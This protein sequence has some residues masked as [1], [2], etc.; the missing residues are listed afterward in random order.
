MR[1]GYA[2]ATLLTGLVVAA[3]GCAHSSSVSPS[4]DGFANTSTGLAPMPSAFQVTGLRGHPSPIRDHVLTWLII[5]SAGGTQKVTPDQVVQWV[6]YTMTKQAD[7][8]IAHALGMKTIFYTDP[9]RV[10]KSDLMYT[11]D[12][13]T[14]AHDCSGSRITVLTKDKFLMD[15]HSKHLWSLWP[16]A[17]TTMM[18]WGG[19][20][21]YDYVFED[22]ADSVNAL[23]MSA[24]PCN[25]NQVDWTTN[26]NLLDKNLGYNIIYNGLSHVP[27]DTESPAPAFYLNPTAFGGMAEDCYVGRSPSGYHYGLNWM[28][29]ENTEIGMQQTGKLFV[30]HGDAYT[31]SHTSMALR[32]YFYASVLLSYD[33][34]T[35]IVN[36]EFLTPSGVT[37]MP[38]VQLVPTNPLVQT[39]T[40]IEGLMQ[41]SGVFGREYADCYL[42]GTDIGPCAVA[43]NSAK[44]TNQTLAFPWPGKYQHTLKMFG[45]GVYDG[46]TVAINGPPPPANMA[47]GTAAIVF[48]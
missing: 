31:A 19:G 2:V 13:T 37:I 14:F 1:I 46:G 7:S 22:T 9:N 48:P 5:G 28:G 47:G 42:A 29:M 30:C 44:P 33:P 8:V 23:R 18:G 35:T 24:M 27:K 3:A 34:N 6:D 10:G 40:A 26:T 21:V 45:K 20:G 41:S 12:E 4:T 39:P 16:W 17:A 43:V 11:K 36:T 38:E 15:V 25:F 32:T